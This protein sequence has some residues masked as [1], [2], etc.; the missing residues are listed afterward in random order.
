MKAITEQS[1]K[2][3]DVTI[4]IWIRSFQQNVK[5]L[6]WKTYFLAIYR[7]KILEDVIQ[8]SEE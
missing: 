8:E 3:V 4:K 7:L 5:K 1:K 2:Q 6:V